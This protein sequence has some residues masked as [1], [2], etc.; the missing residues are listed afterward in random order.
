MWP[1]HLRPLRFQ[2]RKKLTGKSVWEKCMAYSH[3]GT[4]V[5]AIS[6]SRPSLS[7]PRWTCSDFLL[8]R[9]WK[10]CL[11]SPQLLQYWFHWVS[12]CLKLVDSGHHSNPAFLPAQLMLYPMA[13][14]RAPW[15]APINLLHHRA[16]GVQRKTKINTM[17]T[18]ITTAGG[19]RRQI[20]RRRWTQTE[21][22]V[23]RTFLSTC[24]EWIVSNC[25][26][27]VLYLG[28]TIVT[29]CHYCHRFPSD[30]SEITF[31]IVWASTGGKL[32]CR[33]VRNGKDNLC[34]STLWLGPAKFEVDQ[35]TSSNQHNRKRQKANH[36][37]VHSKC[38]GTEAYTYPNNALLQGKSLKFT[39]HLYCLIPPKSVIWWTLT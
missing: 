37:D 28:K 25:S 24:C 39:I 17:C 9:R 29:Y 26:F 30:S 16:P 13:H 12:A 34:R 38:S 35:C 4:E 7:T 22:H 6:A 14:H 19:R 18:T 5:L 33:F 3:F 10:K 27:I 1:S 36:V 32:S 31:R 21:I 8:C 23:T 15:K 20:R 11:V 2:G